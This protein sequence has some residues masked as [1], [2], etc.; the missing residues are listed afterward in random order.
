M[1]SLAKG[2]KSSIET[3]ISPELEGVTGKYFG[4]GGEEKPND[5]YYSTQNEQIVWDYCKKVTEGYL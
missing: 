5:K 2:A 1:I 4:P 3:A